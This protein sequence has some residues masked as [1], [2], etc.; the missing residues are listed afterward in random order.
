MDLYLIQLKSEC[1]KKPEVSIPSNTLM[2]YIQLI[3]NIEMAPDAKVFGWIDRKTIADKNPVFHLEKND[4]V[5]Y[6][7]D[8]YIPVVQYVSQ[9]KICKI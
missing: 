9:P 3:E 5:N 4:G 1:T 2:S 8:S 7:F 6:S